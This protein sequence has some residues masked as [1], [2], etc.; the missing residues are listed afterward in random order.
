SRVICA[1]ITLSRSYLVLSSPEHKSYYN[2]AL[3]KM[4]AF[5]AKIFNFF[6]QKIPALSCRDFILALCGFYQ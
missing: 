6:Q 4:Q 2:T 3:S 1:T 5:F